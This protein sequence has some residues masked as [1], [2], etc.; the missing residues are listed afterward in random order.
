MAGLRHADN[1]VAAR[2]KLANAHVVR[3]LPMP[4]DAGGRLV[5]FDVLRHVG[6]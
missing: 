4:V 3:E 5:G 2:H 6:V 1:L